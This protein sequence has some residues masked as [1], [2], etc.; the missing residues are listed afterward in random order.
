MARVLVMDDEIRGLLSE[1]EDAIR[2]VQADGRI[3]ADERAE[4]RSLVEQVEGALGEP[5]SEHHGV[6]EHLES[7]AVRFEGEHPTLAAVLR[8]A[9]DTLNSYGI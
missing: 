2:R 3:D 7:T 6:T 8:S 4:L 9:V 1:L 5:G